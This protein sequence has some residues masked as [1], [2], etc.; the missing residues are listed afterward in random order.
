MRR[1]ELGTMPFD[2]VDIRVIVSFDEEDDLMIITAIEIGG[3]KR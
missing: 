3:G 2:D 1:V